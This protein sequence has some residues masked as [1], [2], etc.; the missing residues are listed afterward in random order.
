MPK[1]SGD[2][3]AAVLDAYQLARLAMADLKTAVFAVISVL[4]DGVRLFQ[5]VSSPFSA[6]NATPQEMAPAAVPA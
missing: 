5:A 4:V 3:G 6:A 1:N 2:T